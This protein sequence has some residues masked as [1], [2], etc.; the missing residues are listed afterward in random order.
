MRESFVCYFQ[1]LHQDLLVADYAF[2]SSPTKK[3]ASLEQKV[4]S[5]L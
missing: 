4:N 3:L 2:P 5:L 1:I